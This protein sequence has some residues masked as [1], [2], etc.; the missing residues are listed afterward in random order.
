MQKKRTRKPFTEEHRRKLSLARMGNK[1]SCGSIPWNKGIKWSD[2][3]GAR[4]PR[5]SGGKSLNYLVNKE[6]IAGRKKPE[7]C[8]SCG[9][10]R[11]RI[12][13]DHDHKTGKFRGWICDR[14][15]MC[16]GFAR[17]NPDILILLANYVRRFQDDNGDKKDIQ[18]QEK[19]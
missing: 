4:N 13:F 8:E 15:N 17:D 14:C 12:C 19:N 9:G 18:P 1:N 7:L 3:E 11:G 10:R 5:W 16:L 2:M 6:A